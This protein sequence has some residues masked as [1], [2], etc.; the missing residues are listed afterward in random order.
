MSGPAGGFYTNAGALPGNTPQDIKAATRYVASQ[1]LDA[2]DARALLAM[3]GLLEE[4]RKRP[5]NRDAMGRVV[6]RR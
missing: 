3:L 1:A 4:P 5:R 2:A 6:G